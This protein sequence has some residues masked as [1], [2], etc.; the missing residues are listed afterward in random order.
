MA[1]RSV[2]L[3]PG[4][5]YVLPAGA[6]IIS[7]SDPT[8]L[9]SQNNCADLTK[10][11]DTVCRRFRWAVERDSTSTGPWTTDNPFPADAQCS[12]MGIDGVEYLFTSTTVAADD[13]YIRNYV[14]ALPSIG[15]TIVTCYDF[16]YA[17]GGT[18]TRFPYY[19]DISTLSS[20]A[21][22]LY[23]IFEVVDYGP[24][25]IYGETIDCPAPPAP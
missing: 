8:L 1:Y 17:G 21:D 14:N 7:V 2:T 25:R 11:E 10:L 22:K 6:Q 20:I 19:A 3:T 23:F 12:G 9:T 18:A 5:S 15:S 16:A 13:T 24:I 4:E